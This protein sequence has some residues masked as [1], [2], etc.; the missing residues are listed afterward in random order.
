MASDNAIAR[1]SRLLDLIPFLSRNEVDLDDFATKLGITADALRRDLEIAF[2]CGLPGYT[3]DLLIDIAMED[4][5]VFISDPQV[6]DKPRRMTQAELAALQLGL[7]I[8]EHSYL[9]ATQLSSV[10]EGLRRKIGL[11]TPMDRVVIEPSMKHTISI[12]EA[13]ILRERR[14]SFAYLDSEGKFSNLR[15]ASPWQINWIKGKMTLRCFD[16]DRN[17]QREFFLHRISKVAEIDGEWTAPTEVLDHH[18]DKYLATVRMKQAPMW[19]RRRYLSYIDKVVRQEDHFVVT[20]QYWRRSSAVRA[21]LPVIDFLISYE[22]P[23]WSES[24]FRAAMLSHFS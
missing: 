23:D 19:W 8:I 13:A 1:V 6:L 17:A 22:D 9:G 11:S 5:V 15:T 3:P 24:E 16:H 12:I 10:M 21:L 4:G 2:L 14:V 20:L 18:E 7:E